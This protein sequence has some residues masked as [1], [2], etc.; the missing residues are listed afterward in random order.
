[1]LATNIAVDFLMPLETPG[2][3][4]GCYRPFLLAPAKLTH[5]RHDPEGLDPAAVICSGRAGT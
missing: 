3:C 1:M 2:G 4:S 5:S